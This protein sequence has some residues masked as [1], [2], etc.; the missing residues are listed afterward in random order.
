MTDAVPG[1]D[2]TTFAHGGRAHEVYQAGT[3]PAV[4][5]MHELPGLHPGVTAFG[6]RLVDAGAHRGPCR[7]PRSPDPGRARPGDGLPR[8]AAALL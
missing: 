3:G 2:V 1:F 4:V 7:H 6:Q 5:V 8:R